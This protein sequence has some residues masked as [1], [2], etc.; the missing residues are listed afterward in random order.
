MI[1]ITTSEVEKIL[2]RKQFKE[3]LDQDLNPLKGSSVLITGSE[4]SIGKKLSKILLDSGIQ[5]FCS[6]IIGDTEYIDVT[7]QKNVIKKL[8]VL[9]PDIVVHLAGAKHAPVGEHETWETLNINTLGT[10]NILEGLPTN[11]K[12]ILAS[13]CKSANPEIVY[14]ASKLIAERMVLNEG[15]SVSRFFNVIETQGNV[16][17][18]WKALPENEP[19]NVAESCERHFISLDEATGLLL[20]TMMA[21]PGRY[22]INSGPLL[23][24]GEVANRLYPDRDKNVIAPRRGDRLSEKFLATSESVDSYFLDTK[25]IKVKNIHDK[26]NL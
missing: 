13:T 11:S 12:L 5:V 7:D 20:F 18:I 1:D 25:V 24:M 15:G 17:D 23:R 21:E 16:F 3:L 26:S 14:G 8:N 6:D 9:N 2:G 10:K 19:I 22:I 4:G